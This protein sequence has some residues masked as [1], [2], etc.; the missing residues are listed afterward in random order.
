MLLWELMREAAMICER[1]ILMSQ[2]FSVN[3]LK[4][5]RCVFPITGNSLLNYHSMMHRWK[6]CCLWMLIGSV[7]TWNTNKNRN[8]SLLTMLSGNA[9]LNDSWLAQKKKK[10]KPY[11]MAAEDIKYRVIWTSFKLPF[12]SLKAPGLIYCIVA[13]QMRSIHYSKCILLCSTKA[14]KSYVW[15]NRV[16]K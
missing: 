4:P 2:I 15:N 3:Q 8:H 10:K 5:V 6:I 9:P 12:W 13:Y 7:V 1:I 16:S 14:S 11:C